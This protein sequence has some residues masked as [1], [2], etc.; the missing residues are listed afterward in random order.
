LGGEEPALFLEKVSQ[1]IE[2]VDSSSG[3]IGIIES[4]LEIN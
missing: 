4:G 1:A 2:Q 3:A